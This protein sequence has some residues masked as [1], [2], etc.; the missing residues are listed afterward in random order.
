LN[1][2]RHGVDQMQQDL[3]ARGQRDRVMKGGV[4]VSTEA[5]AFDLCLHPRDR[6]L[7]GLEVAI[8]AM[9]GS[10]LCQLYLERL[11][12]FE[13]VRQPAPSLKQLCQG[14]PEAAC[15][16]KE[17][18]LAVADVDK[19]ERLQDHERLANRGPADMQPVRQV[20][21][22]WELVAG[23]HAGLGDELG[24]ALANVLIQATALERAKRCGGWRHSRRVYQGKGLVV[25]P[26]TSPMGWTNLGPNRRSFGLEGFG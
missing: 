19:A 10:E 2:L 13:H 25:Q 23:H 11:T 1:D 12:C 15:P 7:H 6:G 26:L 9:S 24:Q 5:A 20:A 16:A 3:I 18:P 22:G 17:H 21:L 4:A 8:T 14:I